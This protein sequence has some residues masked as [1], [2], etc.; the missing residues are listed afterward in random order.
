MKDVEIWKDVPNFEFYQASNLGRI[1]SLDRFGNVKNGHK[2]IH[3]GK[4]IKPSLLNSGYYVVWLRKNGK[5]YAKTVHRI[6]AQTFLSSPKIEKADV[7]HKDGDKTNNSV[8]NLEWCSRSEN[9]KHSYKI[10]NINR[11]KGVN[12]MCLETGFRYKSVTEA[13]KFSGISKNSISN[14]IN[15]HTKKAGGLTWVKI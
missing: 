9:I 5:T 6:I 15:G 12:V 2:A 14:A 11:S 7:N 4:V 8:D 10:S 1:R 13:S 3:R